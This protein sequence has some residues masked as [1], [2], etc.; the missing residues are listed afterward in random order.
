MISMM[1]LNPLV[2]KHTRN[3]NQTWQWETWEMEVLIENHL[4]MVD[5]PLPPLIIGG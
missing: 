2:I 4:Y 3:V 1:P 5:F